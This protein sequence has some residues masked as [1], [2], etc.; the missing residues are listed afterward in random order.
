MQQN[1]FYMN[2]NI[3]LSH[4]TIGSFLWDIGK[5]CRPRSDLAECG[6]WSGA[7][8][9]AQIVFRLNLNKNEKYHQTPPWNGNG[10]V[11]MMIS[12]GL[13][14]LNWQMSSQFKRYRSQIWI[15]EFTQMLSQ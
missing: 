10:L 14:A 1:Y 13:N 12:F 6:V 4:I 7:S 11:Q 8:L 15:Y 5:Q 2:Q 9:F 3:C